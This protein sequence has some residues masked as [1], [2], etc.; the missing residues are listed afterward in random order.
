MAS[1]NNDINV[2]NMSPFI[3]YILHVAKDD[4]HF[5]INY[6]D[7]FPGIICLLI[8]SRS[9]VVCF[10]QTIHDPRDEKCQHFIMMQKTFQKTC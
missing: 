5:V 7:L 4:I 8:T 9:K 1:S 6:M 2:L 10:V 3:H